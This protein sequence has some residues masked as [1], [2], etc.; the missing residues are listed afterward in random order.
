MTSPH[1]H[2]YTFN[3]PGSIM[4]A[5][6]RMRELFIDIMNIEKQLSQ[7][8][9]RGFDGRLLP[10]NEYKSW[11]S[12]THASLV[13]KRTEYHDLK[14]WILQ[15]RRE[16]EAAEV[17]I[18][19]PNDPRDVLLAVRALLRDLLDDNVDHGDL[20]VV[21]NVVDQHLQHTL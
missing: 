20:G 5:N 8:E 14:A 17:Q 16:V 19:N 9:K 21:Y 11:R 10:R 3:P 7:G 1:A 6:D 4:E 13:Y 12:R 18:N 2:K 15:R